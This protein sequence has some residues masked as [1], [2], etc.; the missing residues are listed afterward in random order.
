MEYW[1][2]WFDTWGGKHMVNNAE[3]KCFAMFDPK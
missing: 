3:G 1:V 2:G